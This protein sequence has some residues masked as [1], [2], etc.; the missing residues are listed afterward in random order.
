MWHSRLVGPKGLIRRQQVG[1]ADETDVRI[2]LWVVAQR[3]FRDRIVLLRQKAGRTGRVDDL[4]EQLFGLVAPPGEQI[5]LD[6]P[7]RADVEAALTAG[8]AV[9]AAVTVHSG[10]TAQLRLD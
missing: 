8:Q 10:P 4:G 2:R 6:Q 7:G 1:A 5:R 3:A 9:V